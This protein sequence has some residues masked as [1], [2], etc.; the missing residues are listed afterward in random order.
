MPQPKKTQRPKIDA[1]LRHIRSGSYDAEIGQLQGAISDRQRLRQDALLA[2]VKTVFGTDY[3]VQPK[4][5]PFIE[6]ARA[7]EP[8]GPEWEQAAQRAQEEE[9]ARVDAL[10]DDADAEALG[11]DYESRSPLIGSVDTTAGPDTPSGE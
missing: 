3:E 9:K 11:A 5:N 1:V 6:R 7:Q 4:R 2:Q 10:G 8:Q